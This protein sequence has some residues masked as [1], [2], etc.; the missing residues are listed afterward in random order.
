MI[1]NK[2]L[3]WAMELGAIF[4]MKTTRVRRYYPTSQD[5]FATNSYQQAWRICLYY[6]YSYGRKGEGNSGETLGKYASGRGL[7]K[8]VHLGCYS[9]LVY[10]FA[11]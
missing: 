6:N 11:C 4:F 1:M 10:D 7:R 5:A 2:D 3:H 9:R 8:A